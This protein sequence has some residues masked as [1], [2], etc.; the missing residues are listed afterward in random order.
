MTANFSNLSI[1]NDNSINIY[2]NNSVYNTNASSG[3]L[4]TSDFYI[5]LSGGSSTLNSSTPSSI[6]KT[7]NTHY[8][9]TLDL[10]GT[11][12]GSELITINPV[13][14]SIFDSRWGLSLST[15]QSPNNTTY[16]KRQF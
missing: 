2:F 1:N 4:E 15:D 5:S 6:S 10:T 16:F 7:S 3:D 13:E 8:V 14:N 12:D 11:S 9:L